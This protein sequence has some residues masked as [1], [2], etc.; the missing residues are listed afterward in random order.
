MFQIRVRKIFEPDK[1]YR[2]LN[3]KSPHEVMHE[4]WA[5][6]GVFRMVEISALII[7]IG[8]QAMVLI[9]ESPDSNNLTPPPPQHTPHQGLSG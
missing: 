8:F 5:Y 3:L 6:C 7:L 1:N 2:Y 9:T 4:I